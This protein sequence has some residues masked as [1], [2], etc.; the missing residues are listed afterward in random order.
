MDLSGLS[1]P[2]CVVLWNGSEV[3]RTSVRHGTRDPEWVGEG[4]DPDAL[5]GG[6]LLAEAGEWVDLPLCVPTRE[7]WGAQPW[8][9]M[10]LEVSLS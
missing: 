5:G 4:D 2:F 1:D 6:G 10:H 3:G 8:P 7:D 9:P